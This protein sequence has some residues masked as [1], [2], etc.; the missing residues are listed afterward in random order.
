MWVRRSRAEQLII[1]KDG[2]STVVAAESREPG[3]VAAEDVFQASPDGAYLAY[4]HIDK[5]H[6][7]AADGSERTIAAYGARS[8]M[9]FSPDS[10]RL[11]ALVDAGTPH[12]VVM[13]LATGEVHELAALDDVR[14]LAWTRE[15]VVAIAGN[16]LVAVPLDGA[17]HPLL[18]GNNLERMAAADG[19]VVVADWHDGEHQVLALAV[20]ASHELS[21]LGVVRDAVTNI[22][23]SRDG[24]HVTFTTSLAVF[25]SDRGERARAISDRG[26]VHESAP[27]PDG[28]QLLGVDRF[29][30]GLVLWTTHP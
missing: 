18:V 1:V 29:A 22:A 16:A 15:G 8:H 25:E 9:R 10:T 3:A 4:A 27:V 20:G 17:P 21:E 12:V 13:E 30:G 5:L 26:D 11:A 14:Q 6:V 24:E 7:R 2:E 23:I 19:R 28:Q